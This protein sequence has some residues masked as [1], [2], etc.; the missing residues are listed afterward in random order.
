[1]DRTMNLEPRLDVFATALGDRA[2]SAMVC[3]LMDGRAYTAKE[4]AYRA[5]VSPQT[6]SFHLRHL[7]EAGLLDWVPQGRN[8]YYRLAGPEVAAAVEAMMTAAPVQHLRPHK[9]R[10]PRELFVARSC[11]DHIAGRLGVLI[12]ERLAEAGALLSR[13]GDFSL[14]PRGLTW[15]GEAGLDLEALQASHRPLVRHCLDWTERRFHVAG[16]LGAALLAH[17]LTAGWLTREEGS[18]ILAVTS[19]GADQ[20]DRRLGIRLEAEEAPSSVRRATAG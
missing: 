4:L 12:A 18:R 20:M 7:A 16:A 13:G 19:L 1:M 17:A 14:T 9:S 6:A 8:R 11:Y 2:R 3:A 10:A 15:L 5:R